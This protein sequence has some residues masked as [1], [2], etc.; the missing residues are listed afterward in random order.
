MRKNNVFRLSAMGMAA[1]F[2]TGIFGGGG[3]MILV[4]L[5]TLLPEFQEET[6][7]P[8]SICII[9]PICMVSILFAQS[10]TMVSWSEISPYLLGSL[11]GGI[12][13]GLFG[14]KIPVLWLHRILG[15][16]VL[17][18]GFRYLCQTTS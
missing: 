15:A 5:L 2:V 12:S 9:L 13:A 10:D 1:G 8:S 18:G 6:I 7:F 11:L 17:W 14:K 4:P 3:G 16:M